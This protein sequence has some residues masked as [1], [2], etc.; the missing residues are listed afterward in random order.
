VS[1]NETKILVVDDSAVV[2]HTVMSIISKMGH[3][4]IEAEDGTAVLPLVEE[5]HPDLII[6]DI[7]MPEKGGFQAL[8]ELRAKEEGGRDTPVIILTASAEPRYVRQALGMGISGY[9]VKSNLVAAEIRQ[10]VDQTLKKPAR[11]RTAAR[12]V[13]E[14]NLKLHVLLADDSSQDRQLLSGLLS[15]WGCLT[16]AV[17]NGKEVLSVLAEDSSIDVLVINDSMPEM[18]GYEATR[19]L[20]K[21][22]GSGSTRLP[23]ILLTSQ[24]LES[25]RERCLEVGMDAY[26]AKPVNPDMLY[27]TLG[28]I[29]ALQLVGE[30]PAG[31]SDAIYD[32]EELME[33]VD[34]DLE[35]LQ[36][37]LVFFRRDYPPQLVEIRSAVE[38]AN[39]ELLKKQAHALRGML[40]N[41]TAYVAAN[42]AAELENVEDAGDLLEYAQMPARLEVEVEVEVERANE[43]LSSELAKAIKNR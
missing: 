28:D 29:H 12:H 27:R 37:M 24:P 32:W 17:E 8:E 9:L 39:L 2:R 13:H 31:S 19:A 43:Q 6:L 42:I 18:D 22:D 23:V 16:T 1:T 21:N 11:T 40:A 34:D 35:L 38:S 5:H 10:R 33:R 14:A 4:V 20:R 3:K 15:K 30:E 25:V 36:R 26:I 7:H 41:L